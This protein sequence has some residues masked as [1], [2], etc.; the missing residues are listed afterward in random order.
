MLRRDADRLADCRRR[1][2]VSPLGSGALAGSPY[3]LDRKGV[4]SALGMDGATRNSMDAVGDRDFAVELAA[5]C[6]L[7]MAHLSRLA[8]EVLLWT[9]AEF[10]FIELDDAWS[11]GSSIMP[12]KKNADVAELT[13]GKAGRVYGDLMALLTI[14]KGLPLAYNRDLQ[15][16]KPALFDAADTAEACLEALA[17]AVATW[18]VRADSMA[19]AVSDDLLLATEYADYLTK[20]GLPFREAHHVAG[21]LVWLSVSSATPLTRLTLERLREA[22]PLFGED[23]LAIS[24]GSALASR[25]VPGGTAPAR[26]AA[27]VA[28][29][30]AWLGSLRA[31]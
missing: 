3:P 26:V 17:G 28:E 27:A 9:S 14:L 11:T 4:A 7:I 13:R 10:S 18:T 6:A 1:L 23:A 31:R 22:S 21:R 20:K 12:Q 15:E 30:R 16:D 8:E 29:A 25:D 5:A 19:A 2:N 24:V